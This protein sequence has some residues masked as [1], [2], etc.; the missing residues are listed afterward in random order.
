MMGE[1]FGSMA[2]RKKLTLR[3]ADEVYSRLIRFC[4]SQSVEPTHNAVIEKALILFL[5]N[6]QKNCRH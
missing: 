3:L 6:G 2:K 5:Q 1:Q 4:Q